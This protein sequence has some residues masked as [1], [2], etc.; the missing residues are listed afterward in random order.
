MSSLTSFVSFS[1]WSSLDEIHRPFR[2]IPPAFDLRVGPFEV[3]IFPC[4][5]HVVFFVFSLSS[6]S[7]LVLV[8]GRRSFFIFHLQIS[9]H[10]NRKY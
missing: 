9:F 10:F 1:R 7:I 6:L 4:V 2:L 8:V 3:L 5:F